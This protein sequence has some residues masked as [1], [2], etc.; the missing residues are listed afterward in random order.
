VVADFGGGEVSSDG[1]LLLLR[2][3]DRRLDLTRRAAELL[4]DDRAPGKVSHGSLA[5]LRQ[6]LFALAHGY[7]DLNDHGDLRRD[8]LLQTAAGSDR[9]LASAPTLCRMENRANRRCAMGLN[10]LLVDLFVEG[11]DAPPAEVILDFD[12]T[13]DPV[14][15]HQDGRAFHGYY[16]SY[17]FLPL[18]V[19]CGDRPLLAW[20]R[21]SDTDGARGAWAALRWLARRL[22]AAWPEVRIILR[23]DSGFCR[24][25]MLRWCE[26]NGV[27]YIVGLPK[28]PRLNSLSSHLMEAAEALHENRGGKVRLFGW[29]R[30]AAGTWDKGRWVI[31]K[32]EHGEK[33]ANPRYLVTSLCG[34]AEDLYDRVYCARGDMENRIK[35]Q[36]L[37]LFAGRTSCHRWWP[38]QLRLMFSTLAY[39]L[40]EA[41]R[42]LAL[43]G[44][45]W[46]R[47]QAGSIRLRLLKVGA[48]VRRN[49]RRIV[50]HLSSSYPYRKVFEASHAKLRAPG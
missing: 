33:G 31:A 18:Y 9:E 34:G 19:F 8:T 4:P 17:C 27:D 50:V 11:H 48:V 37:D 26:G 20:L 24:W 15:G 47:A 10:N 43:A 45:G 41:L 13:D 21:P 7:E 39:A 32:A 40:V 25:R 1:G 49:T 42:R 12:A 22:R 46:A 6:R 44:T 3:V 23:A 5:M 28:N 35:E 16:D 2:E 30:Y 29:M 38:N 36:Q 14:H